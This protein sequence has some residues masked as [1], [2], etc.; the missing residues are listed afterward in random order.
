MSAMFLR[1]TNAHMSS[2]LLSYQKQIVY[3]LRYIIF[4]IVER[5]RCLS[6]AKEN[7]ELVITKYASRS[8]F[9]DIYI[10]KKQQIKQ[11]NK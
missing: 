8:Y 7:D 6:D 9:A 11:T 10:K 5:K 3:N 1:R 4:C 2:Q